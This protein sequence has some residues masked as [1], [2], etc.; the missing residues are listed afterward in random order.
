MRGWVGER[1][2]MRAWVGG[3]LNWWVRVCWCEQ[4][5]V[6]EGVPRGSYH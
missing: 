5:A 2:D 4:V 3:W 6:D 1:V